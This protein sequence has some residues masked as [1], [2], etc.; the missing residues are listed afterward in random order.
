MHGSSLN[1]AIYFTSTAIL[2]VIID[3]LGSWIGAI[4][5]RRVKRAG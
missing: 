3:G 2:L 1:N 4:A 5:V